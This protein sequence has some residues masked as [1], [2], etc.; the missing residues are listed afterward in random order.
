MRFPH[1]ARLVDGEHTAGL[2]PHLIAQVELPADAVDGYV[3]M[4]SSPFSWSSI[5][6]GPDAESWLRMEDKSSYV[7]GMMQRRGWHLAP[8]HIVLFAQAN[9]A[10]TGSN[11][12][13]IAV[14]PGPE[15]TALIYLYWEET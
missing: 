5:R 7:A 2:H 9:T 11:L 1:S 8:R 12:C 6:R 4:Q 3:D 14:Q 15:R 13:W 10:P